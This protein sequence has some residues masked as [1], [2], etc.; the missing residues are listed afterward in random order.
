[1]GPEEYVCYWELIFSV[2]PVATIPLHDVDGKRCLS[3]TCSES[4]T[5]SWIV[6]DN[7]LGNVSGKSDNEL[8]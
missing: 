4:T 1:M 8:F 2:S 5:S 6:D 3:R 7:T